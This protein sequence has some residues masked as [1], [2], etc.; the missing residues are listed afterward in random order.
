MLFTQKVRNTFVRFGWYIIKWP[1]RFLRLLRHLFR[2]PLIILGIGLEVHYYEFYRY[3]LLIWSAELLLYTIDLLPFPEIFGTLDEWINYRTRNLNQV[4]RSILEPIFGHNMKYNL[5]LIDEKSRMISKKKSIV[6]VSFNTINSWGIMSPPLL[7]H[8]AVHVWQYQQKGSV[9]ILRSLLG[10]KT[11]AGY[12][13]GNLQQ[14]SNL[15]KLLAAD[16]FNY[17]Q[18]AEI[19]TDF[20][21]HSQNLPFTYSSGE[22]S[23][24]EKYKDDILAG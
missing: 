13:Y 20:Y 17:E 5:I 4:E 18:Q 9:Y 7:V 22:I 24:L 2:L 14:Y 8:E 23:L 21:K 12:N 19:I 16:K 6:Y 15:P 11:T 10:Q 1:T 3:R